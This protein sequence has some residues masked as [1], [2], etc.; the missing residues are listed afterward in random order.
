MAGLGSR[1]SNDHTDREI[2]AA[3]AI[4]SGWGPL[5]PSQESN[6]LAAG[7]GAA[8]GQGV[9]GKTARR[10]MPAK[11]RN[12]SFGDDASPSY[13]HDSKML[14]PAYTFP[15][16]RRA[17]GA[18]PPP[19]TLRLTI[20]KGIV[21]T[22]EQPKTVSSDGVDGQGAPAD[23]A[24][25]EQELPA[26]LTQALGSGSDELGSP[27]LDSRLMASES[28]PASQG[29]LAPT[30]R[31]PYPEIRPLYSNRMHTPLS[32]SFSRRPPAS[33]DT[34]E[35]DD[36]QLDGMVFGLPSVAELAH[37]GMGGM[38]H[39]TEQGWGPSPAMVRRPP[40][41][42]PPSSA[43]PMPM[44]D[45]RRH[46]G[47]YEYNGMSPPTARRPMRYEPPSMYPGPPEHAYH[48][49]SSG[50]DLDMSYGQPPRQPRADGGASRLFSLLNVCEEL[51]EQIEREDRRK[52]REMWRYKTDVWGKALMPVKKKHINDARYYDSE[53]SD[54]EHPASM[55]DEAAMSRMLDIDSL[56]KRS[57]ARNFP[58]HHATAWKIIRKTKPRRNNGSGGKFSTTAAYM[59]ESDDGRN[60]PVVRRKQVWRDDG[61]VY[62][63]KAHAVKPKKKTTIRIPGV[64]EPKRNSTALHESYTR[65]ADGTLTCARCGKGGFVA[66]L[67]L[68]SHL[69]HCPGTRKAKEERKRL[70]AI[71][72][73]LG[74]D[75]AKFD[76]KEEERF[77]ALEADGKL[78]AAPSAAPPS[79]ELG[80]PSLLGLGG[81]GHA[82]PDTRM[83]VL[84]GPSHLNS[85][86]DSDGY[87][88]VCMGSEEL[89]M[90]LVPH[91]VMDGE[92]LVTRVVS[93]RVPDTGR[94]EDVTLTRYRGRN[95]THQFALRDG[96]IVWTTLT[97]HNCR[98]EHGYRGPRAPLTGPIL[99][100]TPSGPLPGDVT[101]SRM[102][103]DMGN[104][105]GSSDAESDDNSGSSAR[106]RSAR[107]GTSSSHS[108][109]HL[110]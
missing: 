8:V 38:I 9:G 26:S 42:G 62:Q 24:T 48:A 14:P 75:A 97:T 49:S 92:A 99:A 81:S 7:K 88:G 11:P 86:Y 6:A 110:T 44:A 5:P 10:V 23:D 54:Y 58:K 67:G 72:V 3:V 80:S 51:I 70:L 60:P 29:P 18:S 73:A 107:N 66:T 56:C 41:V 109:H 61:F 104:G 27:S 90:P 79:A 40:F 53:D 98:L 45:P 91:E 28:Y 37:N 101:P 34:D 76:G 87:G 39:A 46:H 22:R 96:R 12:M 57:T 64:F 30:S 31:Y 106:R 108:S 32:G 94:W 47:G 19:T 17:D 65:E 95:N 71:Y 20:E 85:G 83:P 35:D 89:G 55:S 1:S 82:Y 102:H 15:S 84:S 16:D 103:R 77:R 43:P 52:A 4:V 74:G 2:D 68:R 59:G 105:G 36:S 69:S 100:A 25:Q 21:V 13:L 63:H 78:P 93:I 33:A 50:H